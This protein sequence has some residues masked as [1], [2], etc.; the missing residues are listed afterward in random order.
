MTAQEQKLGVINA[1]AAYLLWGLAPIYFKLIEHVPAD[2]IMVHR[3]IWS[4]LLLFSFVLIT[5]KWRIASSLLK[6]P[7]VIGKLALSACFLSFNWFVFIWAVNNGHMLDAS[8]GYY[9]N[10]LINVAFGMLFLGEKLRKWQGIAVSLAIMGVLIQ[11]ITLG[12][13]P[14]ISLT[15]ATSFAIYGLLRKKLH[16]DSIVG[17]LIESFIMTPVALCYWVLFVD[18]DT[19]NMINNDVSLNLLLIATSIVTTAPLLCF[20]AAAK[21]LTLSTIGFFQYIGPSIM[22]ILATFY[23][24]EQV[25]SEKLMTFAFIWVALIIYCI[26]SYQSRQRQVT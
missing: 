6:S 9:I 23:Y 21:R 3:V 20:T 12:T 19:S 17:L 8:L 15:L 25:N 4:C 16:V 1:L 24:Q 26:D 18:S 11:I 10:P 7:T 14:I 5:P 13:L 22:F 2:E